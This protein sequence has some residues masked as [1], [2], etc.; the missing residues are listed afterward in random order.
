M[1]CKSNIKIGLLSN[2]PSPYRLPLFQL[3]G[4]QNNIDLE[5]AFN[6]IS[7][8]NRNWR[9]PEKF[10]FK[11]TVLSGRTFS[12]Q[13][14]DLITLHINRG[15]GAWLERGNYNTVI[16]GGW[17]SLAHIET[18]LQC[19]KRNIPVILWS[20]S[21]FGEPSVIRTITLPLIRRLIDLC[22]AYIAYGTASR[23]YL[24]SLGA[25]SDLIAIAFNTVDIELFVNTVSGQE[26]SKFRE[27]YKLADRLTFLY[28][29][30]LIKRKGLEVLLKA[31]GRLQQ[32]Y[33]NTSL[34]LVGTGS[35]EATL[36]KSVED[37]G[38]VGVHF[39]GHIPYEQLPT[40]Y[41]ASD[42]VLLPSLSEVWGLTL[43]EA[44]ASTRPVITTDITGAA[45]D[46]VIQGKTGWIAQ[47]G[48][49]E[50]LAECLASCAA[51]TSNE[52][53]AMGYAANQHVRSHFTLQHSVHGFLKAIKIATAS[54][55]R[56]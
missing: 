24:Q 6:A 14:S 13:R 48:N 12:I 46:L 40:C 18:I 26:I 35:L 23:E 19:H 52:R 43:N 9:V 4:E 5:V 15:I 36:R 10:D 11:S 42:V 53:K 45:R 31:F 8:A 44:M 28:V 37:L 17:L 29:G 49:I 22:S 51:L 20:G 2:I 54:S 1:Q 56:I 47:T 27:R 41:A 3:L 16:V 50:S 39:T 21:T 33:P 7:E 55:V 34:I 30:Q 25:S 32:N 38:L